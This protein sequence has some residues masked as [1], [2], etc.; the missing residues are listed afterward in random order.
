LQVR[1]LSFGG[2]DVLLLGTVKGLVAEAAEVRA[3]FERFQPSAVALAVG[4]RELEE[5]AQAL[6]EKKGAQ[7]AG[8]RLGPTGLTDEL[9]ER[10]E[11]AGDVGD[12][13]LFVS[14]SD[15][16]FV[17]RLSKFGDVELPPPSYQEAVRAAGEKGV[18]AAAVDLDDEAYTDAFIANVSALALFRQAR[19]LRK[20]AKRK[21]RA[22]DPVAFALEWDARAT[23]IAGYR[24][25]EEARE[26]K[27]AAGIG[28]LCEAA[29]RVLALVEVERMAG[30]AAELEKMGGAR[31]RAAPPQPAAPEG[32]PSHA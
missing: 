21:L 25:V 7:A 12:F 32:S 27:I 22:Q 24:R 6:V 31:G 19:Q 9:I 17:R 10:D 13:G 4:P 8:R 28:S 15:M 18:P 20:L 2:R 16:M 14:S 30:V 1:E 29:G 3:Q 5:I 11:D 23:R 26:G